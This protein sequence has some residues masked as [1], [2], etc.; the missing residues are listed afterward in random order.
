MVEQPDNRNM[1][2]NVWLPANFI[3]SLNFVEQSREFAIILD[4]FVPSQFLCSFKSVI[5]LSYEPGAVL[6]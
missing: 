6:M 3:V 1:T 5:T 2:L 4:P